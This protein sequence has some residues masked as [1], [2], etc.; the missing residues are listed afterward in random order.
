MCAQTRRSLFHRRGS[1]DD[2]ITAAADQHISSPRC[3]NCFRTPWHLRPCVPMHKT[4]PPITGSMTWSGH[5]LGI[6]PSVHAGTAVCG[7][8]SH[9]GRRNR[10][11]IATRMV[12]VKWI[13]HA[14]VCAS[15]YTTITRFLPMRRFGVSACPQVIMMLR[16]PIQRFSVSTRCAHPRLPHRVGSHTARAVRSSA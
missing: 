11:L 7:G 6:M 2:A 9:S 4:R 12:A 3:R 10:A 5:W 8:R 16:W 1:H 13:V 15:K 14:A